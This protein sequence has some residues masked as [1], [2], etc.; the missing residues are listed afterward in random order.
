MIKIDVFVKDRNWRKYISNPKRHLKSRLKYINN[1]IQFIKNNKINFSILLAGSNEIKRLNKKFRKKDKIT[2][3]LSFPN[4]KN[5][6][7][8]KIKKK[9]I[10]LGD[11]ILNF[12]KI[13]KKNFKK[14]FDKLWIHGFLHL[15]G[16]KHYKN[17]DYYKMHKLEKKILTK[18]ENN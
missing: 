1:S 13:D 18:I 8:K 6:N 11:L 14:E 4:Y 3:V 2:D 16:H 7:L 9:D 10:Y 17:N 15:L 12:Y 5:L